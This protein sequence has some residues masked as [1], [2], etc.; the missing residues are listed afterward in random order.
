MSRFARVGRTGTIKR[1]VHMSEAGD[2]AVR[3]EA[4]DPRLPRKAARGVFR[5]LVP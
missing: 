1:P 2:E 5:M 4:R 3:P